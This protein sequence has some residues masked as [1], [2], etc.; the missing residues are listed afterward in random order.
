M[1]SVYIIGVFLSLFISLLLFTKKGKS[2]PDKILA[3]WMLVISV[4]LLNFYIYSL[5]YWEVYPHFV[6]IATPVPF[7]HGALLYL[8]VLYSLRKEKHLQKID[9]LHFLPVVLSYL[10]M[11]KFFFFYSAEE[12]HLVDTGELDVFQTFSNI[13]L[14][15]FAVSFIV[16]PILSYKLLNKHLKIVDANFSNNEGISLEWLRNIILCLG[17]LF[18]VTLIILGL[19]FLIGFEFPFQADNIFYGLAVLLII[20]F[21]YYGLRQQNIFSPQMETTITKSEYEKSGL[22]TPLAQ[23]YHIRLLEKM[24]TD[25][26]YL[27]EKLT[28]SKLAA[29]LDISSNHL[30]QVINQYENVNFHDFVNKYRVDEFKAQAKKN[31]HFNILALALESGFNSKSSF[32]SIF[33]KQ[34]GQTPTQY[35]SSN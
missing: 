9:Y 6:G 11:F 22:K 31:P 5:G 29:M 34:T 18:L 30:S 10:Y 21:G 3:V 20:V 26:P 28:L 35:L 19:K 25:K 27:D 24:S 23:Q 32:N 4:Q 8:Y 15:G 1:N 7:L 13:L 12:K 17:G 33:K 14:I 2:L 16:Y